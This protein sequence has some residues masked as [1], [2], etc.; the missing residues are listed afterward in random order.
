MAC[1]KCNLRKIRK[2]EGISQTELAYKAGVSQRQIAFLEQG[3]RNP[4]LKAAFK[5]AAVLNHSIEDIF[6]PSNCTNST[7]KS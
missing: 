7:E 5:I 2:K 1:Q 3:K 4:S 6:L